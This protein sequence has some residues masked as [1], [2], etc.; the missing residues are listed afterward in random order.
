MDEKLIE[1]ID[2]LSDMDKV[3]LISDIQLPAK[4]KEDEQ[5]AKGDKTN[6]SKD[7]SD[8]AFNL[9]GID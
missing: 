7:K 6:G 4:N 2:D 8:E 5:N 3:S 1:D 9:K